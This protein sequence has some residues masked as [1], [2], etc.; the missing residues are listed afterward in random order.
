MGAG[1]SEIGTK[2]ITSKSY[3]GPGGNIDDGQDLGET[4]RAIQQEKIA[5][6][7]AKTNAQTQPK[8]QLKT[9]VSIA[10]PSPLIKR[11]D[12]MLLFGF[13]VKCE[14][15]ASIL[16]ICDGN[17]NSITI[18]HNQR[19]KAFIPIPEHKDFF[20]E[21]NPDPPEYSIDPGVFFV[22]KHILFIHI[23]EEG[24]QIHAEYTQ[25]QLVFNSGSQTVSM[26]KHL[27]LECIDEMTTGE[28]LFCLNKCAEES[29]T[30]CSHKNAC[31]D[32]NES[33]QPHLCHCPYC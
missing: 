24:F 29:L 5:N 17:I 12:N 11:I 16:L 1:S 23:I 27:P 22:E 20:I 32:C 7:M 31:H 6:R 8:F 26:D 21:I 30:G 19:I 4:Y 10:D 3:F 2:P 14:T 9:I 28:C 25:Q 18:P 15:K 33:L 13:G